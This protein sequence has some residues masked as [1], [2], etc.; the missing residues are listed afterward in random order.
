M[1]FSEKSSSVALISKIVV[2]PINS[3]RRVV[4]FV[5]NTHI[6]QGPKHAK[7]FLHGLVVNKLEII[8]T[9]FKMAFC[10]C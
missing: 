5:G 9:G 10:G 7:A 2:S 3:D 6:V 4:D 8:E 1:V